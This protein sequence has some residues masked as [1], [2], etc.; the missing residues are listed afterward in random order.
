MPVGNVG[1]ATFFMLALVA[2]LIIGLYV[3]AYAMHCL[4]VVVRD[5]GD[6]NDEVIW[7]SSCWRR[8]ASCRGR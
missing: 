3:L 5:T 6:G 4:L 8:P 2:E 1:T 7:P